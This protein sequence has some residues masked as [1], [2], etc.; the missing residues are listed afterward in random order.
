MSK[1]NKEDKHYRNAK[2]G[3]YRYDSRFALPVLNEKDEVERYNV[4][5]ASLIVRHSEDK[6]L[7]LYDILDIKKETSNPL[8]HLAVHD[9]NP[10]LDYYIKTRIGMCQ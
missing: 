7:Y 1:E 4:F 6:K 9:K 3:W 2:Y 10:F 5:H 8:E